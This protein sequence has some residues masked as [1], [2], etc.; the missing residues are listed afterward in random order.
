[1]TPPRRPSRQLAAHRRRKRQ[2][3]AWIG[4][5]YCFPVFSWTPD[6][7]SVPN[8]S[9]QC[10]SGKQGASGQH[11]VEGTKRIHVM[12][13]VAFCL[14]RLEQ[15]GKIEVALAGKQMFL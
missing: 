9:V 10:H 14:Q 4:S 5:A 1:M 7:L 6:S 12:A 15:P 11:V 8:L 13:T 2:A 3:A